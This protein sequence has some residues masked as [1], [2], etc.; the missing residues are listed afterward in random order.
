MKKIVTKG[1]L[2]M[3]IDREK[4]A[5]KSQRLINSMLDAIRNNEHI[6]VNELNYVAFGFKECMN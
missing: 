2:V 5:I 4:D 6:T 3:A 1:V